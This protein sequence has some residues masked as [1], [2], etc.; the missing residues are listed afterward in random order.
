MTKEKKEE[1]KTCKDCKHFP[2]EKDLNVK[3]GKDLFVYMN[4]KTFYEQENG[5]EY[6]GK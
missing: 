6:F 5:C 1:I 2:K 4:G 3:C